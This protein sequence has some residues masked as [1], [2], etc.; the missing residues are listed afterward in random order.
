MPTINSANLTL[1]T[2]G[3]TVTIN[4]TFNAVFTPFERQLAG[5][6]LKFHPHVDVWGMDPPGSLTG[7]FLI[8]TDPPLF[9]HTDF[10]VTA[11]A[12]NQELAY[13]VSKPVARSLLQEDTGAGDSDELRCRIRI[14]AVGIPP[15]FTDE[16]FTD[17][18]IL[19]G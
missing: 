14:H 10:A 1:T 7:T 3:Q 5:L 4:V 12:G 17:Q 19:L 16:V 2:V 6:G 18:E 9:P 15:E 11:G 8:D 13:N